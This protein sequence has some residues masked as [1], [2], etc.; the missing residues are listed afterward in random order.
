MEDRGLQRTARI[1]DGRA[2]FF[3]LDDCFRVIEELLSD[4]GFG[5]PPCSGCPIRPRR[6][7]W[8]VES[9]WDDALDRLKPDSEAWSY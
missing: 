3:S 7:I 9:D 1:G 5:F 2:L 4:G 6:T 8:T